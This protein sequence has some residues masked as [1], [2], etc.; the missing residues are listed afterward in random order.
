MVSF[1]FLD[2][3]HHRQR[4]SDLCVPG[5]PS[6]AWPMLS[7]GERAGQ[8]ETGSAASAGTAAGAEPAR[9]GADQERAT[10]QLTG[11]GQGVGRSN[12]LETQ[13]RLVNPKVEDVALPPVTIRDHRTVSV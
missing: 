6:G 7:R 5:A 10:G 8:R 13:R 1:P 11:Q 4:S 9:G 3:P 12:P 2:V